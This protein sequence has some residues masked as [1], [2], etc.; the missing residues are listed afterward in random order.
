MTTAP[1]GANSGGPTVGFAQGL[2]GQGDASKADLP[3]TLVKPPLP[4][5]VLEQYELIVHGHHDGRRV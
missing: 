1:E 4:V 5:V 2:A 3:G